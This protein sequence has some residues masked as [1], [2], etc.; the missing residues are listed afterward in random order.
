MTYLESTQPATSIYALKIEKR[1]VRCLRRK[2]NPLPK[3][4]FR[5]FKINEN[6]YCGFQAFYSFIINLYI[7]EIITSGYN[8]F[9]RINMREAIA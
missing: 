6:I 2:A 8:S 7:L 3:V 1:G 4:S 5:D 9:L